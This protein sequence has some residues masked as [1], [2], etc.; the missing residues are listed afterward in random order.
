MLAQKLGYATVS[1]APALVNSGP[2][3]FF[4]LIGVTAV[5]SCIVYDNTSAAGTIL[6][7]GAL[8]LGQVVHF[9]GMGLAAKN[10]IYVSVGGA[11]TVNV[12][13]V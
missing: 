13:F 1:G 2:T 6:W 8:L 4:G 3:G 7:S 10:G 9:G 11:E 12:L 5:A